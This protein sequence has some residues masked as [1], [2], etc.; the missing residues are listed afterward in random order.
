LSTFIAAMVAQ[1][2]SWWF[3]CSLS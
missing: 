2:A 1:L 3:L